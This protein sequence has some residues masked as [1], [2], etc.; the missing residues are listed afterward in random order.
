MSQKLY[1]VVEAR[2]VGGD[3]VESDLGCSWKREAKAREELREFSRRFPGR[4]FSL[5]KQT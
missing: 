1:R 3:R 2:W 4:L 5:Q